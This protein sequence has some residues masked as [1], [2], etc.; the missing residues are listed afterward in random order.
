MF[1]DDIYNGLG[2]IVL[3]DTD[4][5]TDRNTKSQ[6]DNTESNITLGARVVTC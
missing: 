4:K 6:T 1:V 3:T 2:V 5:Q